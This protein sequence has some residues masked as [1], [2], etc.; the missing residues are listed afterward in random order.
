MKISLVEWLFLQIPSVF[1][2]KSSTHGQMNS[3]DFL[4]PGCYYFPMG[5]HIPISQETVWRMVGQKEKRYSQWVFKLC[6]LHV[7]CSLLSASEYWKRILED[8]LVIQIDFSPFP[9]YVISTPTTQKDFRESSHKTQVTALSKACKFPRTFVSTL[10]K[11]IALEIVI[12]Q[13]AEFPIWPAKSVN[14]SG[15]FL[16]GPTAFSS[17]LSVSFW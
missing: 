13:N 11:W 3:W 14:K 12:Q 5:F 4:S 15:W 16:I 1:Q 7:L 8:L 9:S 17:S 6:E 2:C 10:Q